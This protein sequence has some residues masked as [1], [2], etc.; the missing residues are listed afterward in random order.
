MSQQSKPPAVRKQRELSTKSWLVRFEKLAAAETRLSRA[1]WLCPAPDRCR[2][3]TCR[4]R[5]GCRKVATAAVAVEAAR[6]RLAAAS[7]S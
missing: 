4:R 6:A 1:Q 3:R 5:K 7:G 2:D